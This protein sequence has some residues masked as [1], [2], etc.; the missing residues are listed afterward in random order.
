MKSQEQKGKVTK[1]LFMLIPISKK[2]MKR[3]HKGSQDQLKESLNHG[4]NKWL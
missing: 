2:I 3:K 4:L 1:S